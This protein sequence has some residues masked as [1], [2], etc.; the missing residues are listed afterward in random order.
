LCFGSKE[1]AYHPFVPAIVRGQGVRLCHKIGAPDR[2]T[3]FRGAQ[4]DAQNTFISVATSIGAVLK[5]LPDGSVNGSFEL[6][7]LSKSAVPSLLDRH[8][9]QLCEAADGSMILPINSTFPHSCVLSKLAINDDRVVLR[10]GE[11]LVRRPI[12]SEVTSAIG[13]SAALGATLEAS[14]LRDDVFQQLV[15]ETEPFHSLSA[16]MLMI[17]SFSLPMLADLAKKMVM[18]QMQ[19]DEVSRQTSTRGATAS[20][21]ADVQVVPVEASLPN[22]TTASVSTQMMVFECEGRMVSVPAGTAIKIDK[23]LSCCPRELLE[24]MKVDAA[25]T[26]RRGSSSVYTGSV[27]SQVFQWQ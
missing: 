3:D 4:G 17:Y 7:G 23:K 13:F 6:T 10:S 22:P 14:S 16:Q 24:Q 25:L 2:G 21:A 19:F 1:Q 12:R 11:S 5:G 26:E 9:P 15:W 20:A 27:G 18:G 8:R